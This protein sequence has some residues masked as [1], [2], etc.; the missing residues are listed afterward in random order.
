LLTGLVCVGAAFYFALRARRT[1][2][3][4]IRHL[5]LATL[6]ATLA[7]TCA[8]LGATLNTAGRVLEKDPNDFATAGHYVIEG[9]AESMSP[10]ILGFGML[11]VT[12]MLVAVGKRRLD[13]RDAAR[14]AQ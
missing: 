9:F 13:E 7:S 1:S 11:A 12:W 6:F 10:G 14:A 2:L 4:F 8:D 5:A 3:G